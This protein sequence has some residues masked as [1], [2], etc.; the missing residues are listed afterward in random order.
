MANPNQE[1]KYTK[2]SAGIGMDGW[3]GLLEFGY[4][5]RNIFPR[6]SDGHAM[7]V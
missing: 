7:W 2:V 5:N 1:I 3:M 4:I 6:F